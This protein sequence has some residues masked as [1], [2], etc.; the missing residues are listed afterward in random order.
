VHQN[1]FTAWSTLIGTVR[2]TVGRVPICMVCVLLSLG[3]CVPGDEIKA[4]WSICSESD[5]RRDNNG[6][7]KK[8]RVGLLLK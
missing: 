6:E 2:C 5:K 7:A 3:W 4:V 8:T 1:I